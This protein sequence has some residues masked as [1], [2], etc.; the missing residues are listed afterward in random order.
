MKNS[1]TETVIAYGVLVYVVA[2]CS[3]CGGGSST[4][5]NTMSAAGTDASTA[6]LDGGEVGSCTITTADPPVCYEGG[7]KLGSVISAASF[8]ANCDDADGREYSPEPCTRENAIGMCSVGEREGEE[9]IYVFYAGAD[10]DAERTKC[11]KDFAEYE[12]F[13]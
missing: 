8:K 7:E 3:G 6:A 1:L 9:I 10:G 4:G 13:E 2:A 5:E 11:E 12:A